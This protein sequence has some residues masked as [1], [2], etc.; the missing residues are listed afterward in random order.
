MRITENLGTSKKEKK[1]VEGLTSSITV[2]GLRHHLAAPLS[3]GRE[4]HRANLLTQS[5]SLFSGLCWTQEG[6]E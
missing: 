5:G 1:N 4:V 2:L 3:S 6:I